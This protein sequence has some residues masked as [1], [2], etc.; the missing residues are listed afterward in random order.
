MP[1]SVFGPEVQ[2]VFDGVTTT[3]S[4]QIRV[5]AETRTIPTPFPSP[6]DWRDQWIYFLM[7]DRFNNPSAMPASTRQ[8]PAVGFDQPFG[9]F[10]GG[11]FNGVM[12]QLDYISQLGAGAIWMT[13]VLKNCQYE[14]G[15]FHGYGI[16]DFIRA[17]PRFASDPAAALLNPERSDDELRTL[18]DA[19]HAR[20]M[21]V[22]FDIVLNHAGNVFGYVR[23]GQE[24]AAD[25]PFQDVAYPIRWHDRSI[26][27]RLQPGPA[28]AYAR[29]RG[30]AGRV[31]GQSIF[32][33][34]RQRRRPASGQGRF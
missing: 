13:P 20:G 16:Q 30:V 29:R 23:D 9:E 10:Q 34:T 24:N 32:S 28:S 1:S 8:T 15:T 22:I 3:R 27:R 19:I 14:K 11:T 5:G 25:A 6:Q 33:K 26:V 18:V 21:Y 31:A 7:I 17:E 4:R 2:A 12:Q